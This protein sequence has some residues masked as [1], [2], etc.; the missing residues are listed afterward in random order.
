MN[1]N[2]KL[3]DWV[4]L[5]VHW[6]TRRRH[7]SRLLLQ[8]GVFVV[9]ACLAGGWTLGVRGSVGALN[10]VGFASTSDGLPK[11]LVVVVLFFG[12][13]LA[14]MGAG[15][16]LSDWKSFRKAAERSAVVVVELRG[17]I[18]TSD[19][20]L[21]KSLPRGLMGQR[22]DA[23]I[24][25]RELTV[26]GA[27]KQAMQRVAAMPD[28]IRRLR[29]SRAKSDVQVV[30]GGVLPVP[31]L[32][33]A[34]AM[35][36]DE[37]S[38]LSF[39]WDRVSEVWKPL[40]EPDDGERFELSGMDDLPSGTPHVVLAISAS[41][42]TD[43]FAIKNSFG[44]VPVVSLSLTNPLPGTLWSGA[45]QDALAAQFAA[46][47]ATLGN[48]GVKRISLVLAASSTLAL[49]VGRAYDRRNMPE[50]ACYQYERKPKPAYP[51]SVLI[52]PSDVELIPTTSEDVTP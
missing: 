17:L 24:D 16:L 9:A 4:S 21:L 37:G 33:L 41:Y 36:D 49:R 7:P 40:D 39:D 2:S 51:W 35:L 31:L 26:A 14:L 44:E 45:K 8:A 25:V 20:S 48:K 30:V 22:L 15:V 47:V 12:L 46:A 29:G 3:Q 5:L 27:I 28:L 42:L 38:V 6:V 10:L 34:G 18:D 19:S 11:S 50:I 43:P 1:W 52:G 23:L 13:F 32:F